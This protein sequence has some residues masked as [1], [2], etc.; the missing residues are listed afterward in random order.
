MTRFRQSD[1]IARV[2][3]EAVRDLFRHR[4]ADP[5]LLV[6]HNGVAF[7]EAERIDHRAA[8]GATH[9]ALPG[10]IDNIVGPRLAAPRT[11]LVNERIILERLGVGGIRSTSTD[12]PGYLLLTG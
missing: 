7:V 8:G 5:T 4:D 12:N 11:V 9:C 3:G 6:E 10:P 2:E 1:E